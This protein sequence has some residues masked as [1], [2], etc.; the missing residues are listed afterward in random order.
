M[1]ATATAT[2]AGKPKRERKPPAAMT[3]TKAIADIV[4]LRAKALEAE[5]TILAQLPE[6][7]RKR[8]IA[9]LE[10]E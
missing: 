6:A 7:D 10:A 5:D 2:P 8:V 1:T 9:F 3:P 4:K